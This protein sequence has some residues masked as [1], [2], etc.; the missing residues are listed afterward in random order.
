MVWS[1]LSKSPSYLP[2]EFAA[3]C[4]AGSHNQEEGHV[5]VPGLCCTASSLRSPSPI[6]SLPPSTCP[7]RGKARSSQLRSSSLPL[8]VLPPSA[9]RC[10]R[11]V[12]RLFAMGE[13]GILLV[14]QVGSHSWKGFSSSL[15]MFILVSTAVFDWHKIYFLLG[16]HRFKIGWHYCLRITYLI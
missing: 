5:S 15:L 13:G 6:A 11:H 10:V 1:F 7:S 8:R 16:M 12:L 14:R 2:G 3:P 4:K 9:L